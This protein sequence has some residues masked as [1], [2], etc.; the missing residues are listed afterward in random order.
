VLTLS[1]YKNQ[2]ELQFCRIET[3]V[4]IS[5][6]YVPHQA[7]IIRILATYSV[8]LPVIYLS[9]ECFLET[10]SVP[11]HS[12]HY[13]LLRALTCVE[14]MKNSMVSSAMHLR[15]GRGLVSLPWSWVWL[16]V[17]AWP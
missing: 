4:S 12:T 17:R 16:T 13:A 5:A 7:A 2:Q 3:P 11:I 1:D 14:S 6:Y 10:I 15:R 9:R 8:E